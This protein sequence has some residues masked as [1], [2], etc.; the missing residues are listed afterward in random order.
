MNG[1]WLLHVALLAVASAAALLAVAVATWRSARLARERLRSKV[2]TTFRPVLVQLLAADSPD[3]TLMGELALLDR[4]RWS[5][6][7]PD[8]LRFM[9]KV[10]GASRQ[11]LA[12]LLE[13]RGTTE[14]ACRRLASR[15]AW[16]RA[17]AA[18]TL[19]L[20][21]AR[22]AS[23]ELRNMLS[24]R[25]AL[26][27]RAA[28]D[29]L[30]QLGDATSAAPLL[31]SLSSRRP[32]PAPVVGGAVLRLGPGA[33]DAVTSA[34]SHPDPAVN[35]LAAELAG[36]LGALKA[37][38]ALREMLV[39]GPAPARVAA[40][41]ALGRLGLPGATDALLVVAVA[42]AAAA[43][44]VATVADVAAGTGS[45]ELRV[46]ALHALGN[47]GDQG[48]APALGLLL[49]DGDPR[50]AAAA[51][52]ALLELGSAGSTALADAA[53][54]GGPTAGRTAGATASPVEAARAAALAARAAFAASR[55][56]DRASRAR[57]EKADWERGEGG[58]LSAT[59]PSATGRADGQA[60]RE[61]AG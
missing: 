46:A 15:V 17:G 26:A 44:T 41:S 36:R 58:G 53:T 39:S 4:R 25:S 24:D 20:I 2:T 48:V 52:D 49:A 7:E 42:A 57:A 60:V 54:E 21:G 1:A 28:A 19:G 30:G 55:A 35:E 56:L 37:G 3:P 11:V 18:H 8:L 13:R 22:G 51:A 9:A 23:A 14:R 50:V 10:R 38:P 43:A 33:V 16:R 47:I 5:A 32:V 6:L 34:L 27:R 29:A 40:A 61:A 31:A 12:D 59:S 45:R